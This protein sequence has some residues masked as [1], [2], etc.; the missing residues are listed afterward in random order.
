VF[1]SVLPLFCPLVSSVFFVIQTPI[2]RVWWRKLY[3]SSILPLLVG[4]FSFLFFLL[5]CWVEIHCRIYKNSYNI[6]NI[7]YLNSPPPPFS[8]ISPSPHSWNSF[9]S[10]HFSI[11]NTCVH[12]ICTIF[13]LPHSFSI[14]SLSHWYQ[15]PQ[16]G[17]CSLIFVKERKKNDLFACLR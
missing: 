17:P 14:S 8:F 2:H 11:Y 9:N 5:L 12:S 16:T 6:S 15:F 4:V 7:S 10:Y 1:C 13:S 3:F